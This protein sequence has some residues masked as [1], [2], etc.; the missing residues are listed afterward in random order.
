MPRPSR[1]PAGGLRSD[2]GQ[3][4]FVDRPG[5]A[6]GV[7]G[8]DPGEIDP[9]D[10]FPVP[11]TCLEPEHPPGVGYTTNANESLKR[12][13]QLSIK[14]RGSFLSEDAAEKLIYLAVRGHET[15]SRTVREWLTAVNQFAIM[16]AGRFSPPGG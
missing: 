13:I 11:R 5:P 6:A 9:L 15:T 12:A 2:M 16:L 1:R 8:D 10:R 14:T 7:A 4:K 3:A